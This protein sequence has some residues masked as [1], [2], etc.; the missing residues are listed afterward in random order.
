MAAVPLIQY[1]APSSAGPFAAELCAAFPK[2]DR[3]PW[4]LPV[5]EHG[6]L[7]PTAEAR[8]LVPRKDWQVVER[9]VLYQ[10]FPPPMVTAFQREACMGPPPERTRL[11]D[12]RT[13]SIEN[14]DALVTQTQHRLFHQT[15]GHFGRSFWVVQGTQGGHKVRFTKR[16][17]ALMG[18]EG[19]PTT[20]PLKGDL[21]YAEIDRRCLLQLVGWDRLRQWNRT[22]AFDK[23]TKADQVERLNHEEQAFRW[24]LMGWLDK[25]VADGVHDLGRGALSASD[26]PEGDRRFDESIDMVERDFIH[27]GDLQPA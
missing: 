3:V 12:W 20:P 27:G 9:W 6:D 22:L 18:L 26:L 14:P 25:Q 11:W 10:M 21:S 15:G 5:W 23:Q 24:R 17:S 13:R 4:L 1:D 19:K 2:N 8:R 7:P 16:E